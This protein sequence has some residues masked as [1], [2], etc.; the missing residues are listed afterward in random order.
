MTPEELHTA[1]QARGILTTDRSNEEIEKDMKEWVELHCSR[2][3]GDLE[4]SGMCVWRE[5]VRAG[6]LEQDLKK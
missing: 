3:K 2:K 1:A 5:V 6:L 4:F